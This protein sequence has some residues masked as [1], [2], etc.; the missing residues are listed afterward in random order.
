MKKSF[1]FL[2]PALLLGLSGCWSLGVQ[3]LPNSEM[4]WQMQTCDSEIKSAEPGLS[5]ELKYLGPSEALPTAKTP[6]GSIQRYVYPFTQWTRLFELSI[7][8]QSQHTLWLEP[9]QVVLDFGSHREP[10]LT[11]D[12][13]ERAW[14]SGAVR[15]PEEL[16]DRSL[17]ISEI[18]TRLLRAR[19]LLPGED[20]TAIL[21]F[22][23]FEQPP[24]AL[25]LQDWRW[26]EMVF[27][28]NF[29]LHFSSKPLQP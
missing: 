18:D 17:A 3:K 29:C 14:P 15:S 12:F 21:A 20:L 26:G 1:R 28:Q 8:N 11:Q 16:L 27:N 22:R 10:A 23:S 2:A 7:H 13:F 6:W 25:K 5:W 9:E 19:P 24:S 4:Q